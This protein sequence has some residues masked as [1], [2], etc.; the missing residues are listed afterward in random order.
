MVERHW[1]LGRAFCH[2]IIHMP[3]TESTDAYWSKLYD[4][5]RDFTL[6][7]HG[8]LSRILSY[9]DSAL[10]KTCLDIGCGTG[11][12]TREL[13]HRGYT[14]TGIDASVSAIQIAQS[15]TVA[16]QDHP[17]YI[18]FDIEQDNIDNLPLQQYSLITC[19]LVY[20][21]IKDKPTF[22]ESVKRLLAPDGI[23]VVITP[24][25]NNVPAERRGIAV[26]DT[27]LTY[28]PASFHQLALYKGDEPA[29]PLTYFVGQAHLTK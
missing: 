28:L 12:L 26:D 2:I 7:A 18:H 13:F 16:P 6:M 14:C 9:A 3:P 22:L 17:Q 20:A 21:F 25:V 19:K 15:L 1:H 8:T 11:Q 10:P 5:G 29:S 24:H 23:F 4:N 27:D